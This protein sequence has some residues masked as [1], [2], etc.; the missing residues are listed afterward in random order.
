MAYFAYTCTPHLA[1]APSHK[2]SAGTVL[3][4]EWQGLAAPGPQ[5]C[6]DSDNWQPVYTVQP[7]WP[8]KTG[9]L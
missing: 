9:I 6:P 1:A 4:L 7:V 8:C 5:A 2:H 3:I